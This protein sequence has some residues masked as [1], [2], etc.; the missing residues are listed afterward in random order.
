MLSQLEESARTTTGQ[1]L[2][3]E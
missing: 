3:W 1:D 2:F